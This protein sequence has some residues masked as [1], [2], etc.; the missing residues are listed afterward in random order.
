MSGPQVTVTP[1]AGGVV[2]SHAFRHACC[3]RSRIL[4]RFSERTVVVSEKLSGTP[5]RCMCSSRLRTTV[6]LAPGKWTVVVDLDSGKGPE[7]VHSE[8]LVVK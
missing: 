2:V 5:C 4:P 7:R 3:L 8:N 1:V 6:G